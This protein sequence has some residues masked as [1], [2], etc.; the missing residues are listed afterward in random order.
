MRI[1]LPICF[2]LLSHLS[3]INAKKET[4]NSFK[5]NPTFH[6]MIQ[7][8]LLDKSEWQFKNH[9]VKAIIELL[10]Q[11]HK[12]LSNKQFSNLNVKMEEI[13][14]FKKLQDYL[15]KKL[16]SNMSYN[17]LLET[18]QDLKE[19]VLKEKLT[20]NHK[21]VSTSKKNQQEEKTLKS[22]KRL[23]FRWG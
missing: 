3:I 22:Y 19:I 12:L 14:R 17:H 15:I 9:L 5:F 11:Y 8:L 1:I 20:S 18:Y 21:K 7:T 4:S 6:R 2:L 13:V 23:P 16:K 10:I